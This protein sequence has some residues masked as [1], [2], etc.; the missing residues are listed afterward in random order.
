[1][2][3]E[4]YC[5]LEKKLSKF[6]NNQKYLNKELAGVQYGGISSTHPLDALIEVERALKENDFWCMRAKYMLFE[7]RLKTNL[8]DV[9]LILRLKPLLTLLRSLE[10][11]YIKPIKKRIEKLIS[12][13]N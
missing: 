12:T 3:F 8:K 10:W 5:R 9:F 11:N 2:D 6:C 4:F 13:D 7:N 1:M